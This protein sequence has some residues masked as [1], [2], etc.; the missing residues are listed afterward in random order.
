MAMIREIQCGISA[1]C[2][3][4]L[5]NVK[6]FSCGFHSDFPKGTRSS[7]FWVAT[8]SNFNSAINVSLYAIILFSNLFSPNVFQISDSSPQDVQYHGQ[9]LSFLISARSE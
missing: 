7:I 6:D 2:V 9:H 4:S 5:P 3:A 8:D 1:T